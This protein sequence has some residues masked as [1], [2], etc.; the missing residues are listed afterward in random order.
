MNK[1]RDLELN[2]NKFIYL[3]LINIKNIDYDIKKNIDQI[4]T[5]KYI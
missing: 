5:F 3:L 4:N 1:K 2:L